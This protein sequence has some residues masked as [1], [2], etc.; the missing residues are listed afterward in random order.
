MS[1]RDVERQVFGGELR[2]FEEM[3]QRNV[4]VRELVKKAQMLEKE[5]T[6]LKAE[7][8]HLKKQLQASWKVMRAIA[9]AMM[10]GKRL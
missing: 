4:F 3:E 6:T 7:N 1:S 9:H 10:T 2:C 5:N 8:A